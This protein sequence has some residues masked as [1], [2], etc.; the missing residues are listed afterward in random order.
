[1]LVLPFRPFGTWGG[2]SDA[3]GPKMTM[4]VAYV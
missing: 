2:L 4:G 1:M 3:A